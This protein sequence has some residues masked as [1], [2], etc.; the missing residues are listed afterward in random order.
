MQFRDQSNA[1]RRRRRTWSPPGPNE[2]P[3]CPRTSRAAPKH[4]LTRFTPRPLRMTLCC[5]GQR[6]PPMGP[7]MARLSGHL[8]FPTLSPRPDRPERS[9]GGHDG[10]GPAY[11]L[12]SNRP[13]SMFAPPGMGGT[14]LFSAPSAVPA[15]TRARLVGARQFSSPQIPPGRSAGRRWVVLTPLPR[16]PLTLPATAQAGG[17]PGPSRT[18]LRLRPTERSWWCFLELVCQA[19]LRPRKSVRPD[20]N[21]P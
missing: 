4:R 17:S 13:F 12:A 18:T 10:T 19:C 3:E 9:G 15:A 20:R 5:S 16:A 6:S 8:G 21:S 11:W 7:A 14:S 2:R 1:P